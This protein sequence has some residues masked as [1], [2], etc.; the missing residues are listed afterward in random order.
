MNKIASASILALALLSPQAVA[1]TVQLNKGEDALS[2]APDTVLPHT[3][4]VGTLSYDDLKKT[5]ILVRKAL[6]QANSEKLEY[7]EDGVSHI[8][9]KL[10]VFLQQAIK[11]LGVLNNEEKKKEILNLIKE[12]RDIAKDKNIPIL[13]SDSLDQRK[14]NTFHVLLDVPQSIF[15]ELENAKSFEDAKTIVNN[16]S[17]KGIEPQ[18]AKTIL[19]ILKE[20]HEELLKIFGIGAILFLLLSLYGFFLNTGREKEAHQIEIK[21]RKYIDRQDRRVNKLTLGRII[22]QLRVALKRDRKES[23]FPLS[24]LISQINNGTD[25]KILQSEVAVAVKKI[26]HPRNI[27]EHIQRIIDSITEQS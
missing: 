4:T 24:N 13:F 15:D 8:I 22:S 6:E 19:K 20:K 10:Q 12:I 7:T 21:T 1:T 14:H 9:T 18:E 26:Y 23:Q 2:I 3:K 17:T 5:L 25:P 11:D 27:P 16:Y